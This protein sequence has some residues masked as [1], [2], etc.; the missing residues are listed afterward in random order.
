MESL[1]AFSHE[2]PTAIA[3]LVD[4]SI[5]A[6]AH[7]IW[8][9]FFWN[10]A[11]STIVV[12]D[13]GSGMSEDELVA[14]MR[15]GSTSPLFVYR[16]GQLLVPG[17]WLGLGWAKEEHYK[18]T[19]I[20]LD[21]PN[22]LDLDS[23]IDVTKSRAI[24]APALRDDL[25]AIAE[26]TRARAKRVYTFRGAK[27]TPAADDDRLFIWQ[28]VARHDSVTYRLNREHPLLRQAF[29]NARDRASLSALLSLI[30]ETVP[31]AHIIIQNTEK[32]PSRKPFLVP[33]E[34]RHHAA[35]T[36][37]AHPFRGAHA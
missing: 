35:R 6:G 31:T 19:R 24:P 3:D 16:G 36:S 8:I 7:R 23:A 26:R 29:P 5:A 4:N 9:D 20:Q 30:E 15:L 25:R 12:M 2:L 32:Q 27:P 14:A 10:G 22:D 17:D 34:R 11:E 33:D 13:D 1:R 18:L 21:I 37:A 28:P